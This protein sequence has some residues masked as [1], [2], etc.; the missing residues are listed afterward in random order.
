[1]RK[2]MIKIKTIMLSVNVKM[3]MINTLEWMTLI[4]II[5]TSRVGLLGLGLTFLCVIIYGVSK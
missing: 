1:M 3:M 4:L 2:M 5:F